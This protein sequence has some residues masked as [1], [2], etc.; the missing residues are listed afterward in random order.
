[1]HSFSICEALEFGWTKT[2]AHS[3]L[4]FRVML[5]L[6]ALDV[7]SAIVHKVLNDTL[8]GVGAGV[9]FIVVGVIVGAGFTRILLRIAQGHAAHYQDLVPPARLVW[10][11]FC[12]SV[13]A[14]V[15]TAVG[16][17]ALIIPGIYLALR[18]SMVRFAVLDGAG[19]TESLRQSGKET[20]GH[21]WHLLG[22]FLV[23]AGVNLVGLLL[24]YVGLLITV[25]VSGLAWAHVY[26]KL[27]TRA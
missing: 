2:K 7:A 17:V 3:G 6:F 18:F 22:L 1:M 23:L 13:V 19:I 27:K 20:R 24:L 26:L 4:L 12:A 16:L 25:P 5:T 14:G 21:K 10:Y 9:A 15:I 8:L 11:F